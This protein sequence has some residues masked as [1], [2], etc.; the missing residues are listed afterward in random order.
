MYCCVSAVIADA[1]DLQ[2]PAIAKISAPALETGSIVAAVPA[3]TGALPL[4]PLG[5]TVAQFVDDARDFVPWDAGVLN[6]GPLPFFREHVTV[7]DATGLHLDA[8]LSYTRLRNLA[9][10]DLE[11]GSPLGNLRHLHGRYCDFCC[12]HKSSFEF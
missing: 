1:R 2:I 10:D 12:C 8:H 5:N 11:I 4:L 3:D 7:A 9:L 6:A